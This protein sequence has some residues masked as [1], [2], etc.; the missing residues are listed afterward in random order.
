[1]TCEDIARLSLL[2]YGEL[3]F[4]EEELVDSHLRIVP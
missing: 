4:D 1:M 2:L 3:S